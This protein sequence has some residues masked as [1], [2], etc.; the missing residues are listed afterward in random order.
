V[1]YHAAVGDHKRRDSTSIHR[2]D[3]FLPSPSIIHTA[4]LLPTMTSAI[5]KARKRLF[6]HDED[7]QQYAAADTFSEEYVVAQTDEG[8]TNHRKRDLPPGLSERDAAVLRTVKHRANVLDKSFNLCGARFGWTLIIA[9]VPVV[10]DALNPVLGYLLVV[11]Q[12]SKAKLPKAL[13]RRMILN[14]A[15]SAAI[16]IVPILGDVLLASYRA[17]VRN[18]RLLENFLRLRGERLTKGG[19]RPATEEKN[20]D[21][22]EDRVGGSRGAGGFT[23]DEA[24]ALPDIPPPVSLSQPGATASIVDGEKTTLVPDS[25][26]GG[27]RDT[28]DTPVPDSGGDDG[29]TF[30]RPPRSPLEFV[31]HR[32]SRFIEDVS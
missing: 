4:P 21:N 5:C 11:R 31:Q 8:G 19:A 16:G 26:E 6:A 1:D 30:L 22:D 15:I 7:A 23:E 32:D 27:D 12:A 10:G 20:N 3:F 17:N 14:L 18:A 25:V 9:L 28:G 2:N 13:T 24:S 29:A